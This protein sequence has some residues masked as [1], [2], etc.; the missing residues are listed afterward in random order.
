VKRALHGHVPSSRHSEA[1]FGA[2][3]DFWWNADHLR[4][5]AAKWRLR[6]VA[7]LLVDVGCGA[8][9]WSRLLYRHA[10]P[11]AQLVCVDK[12][13]DWA[14][15]AVRE[16]TGTYPSVPKKCV[17]GVVADATA[18]PLVDNVADLVTCQTLL[19]HVA[20][21]L[22][23]VRE[24]LRVLKAGGL[25]VCAEPNNL[26]G[27]ITADLSTAARP[28]ET[29]VK[30]YEFWLRYQRGKASLGLGDN[31]VGDVVPGIFSQL[32][33]KDIEVRLSDKASPILPPYSS[34]EQKTI[35]EQ[36]LNWERSKSGPW[37]PEELNLYVCAGGGTT[38]M[39]KDYL[40]GARSET[41]AKR[42][43]VLAGNYY[44]AGASIMYVVWG[45][46]PLSK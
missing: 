9:H 7:S 14:K 13:P 27:A 16:F 15:T 34:Q 8:G 38:E 43:A 20:D 5:L 24:M 10:K 17:S 32:G 11:G 2:Q 36:D 37:D 22:R 23:A 31:S 12:E 39:V 46:K 26:F 41:K 6:E 25:L 40:R 44:N 4:L 42:D 21:P 1:Y 28:V 35:L 29:L 18:L 30:R 45:K 19:I 33:L 3:R